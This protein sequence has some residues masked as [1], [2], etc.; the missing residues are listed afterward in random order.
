[1]F[2]EDAV[3]IVLGDE[4]DLAGLVT[5][6]ALA[7][8]DDGE[9]LPTGLIGEGLDAGA[10]FRSFPVGMGG[11]HQVVDAAE[12]VGA[13]A[14]TH[15]LFRRLGQGFAIVVGRAAKAVGK[16]A[17]AGAKGDVAD[18]GGLFRLQ[19]GGGKWRMGFHGGG[20]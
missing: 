17:F 18:F 4:F 13:V 20:D 3:L 15:Q 1:M 14:G 6:L 16:A 19:M 9:E 10:G 5:G 2:A 7:A 8:A 11:V 12:K